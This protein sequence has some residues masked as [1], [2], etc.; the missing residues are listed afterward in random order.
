M[1]HSVI[2]TISYIY[3]KI[4]L[5]IIMNRLN[6]NLVSILTLFYSYCFYLFIRS[7]VITFLNCPFQRASNQHQVMSHRHMNK[8]LQIHDCNIE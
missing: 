2:G 3:C 5:P 7:D 8:L 4:R 6:I 1:V